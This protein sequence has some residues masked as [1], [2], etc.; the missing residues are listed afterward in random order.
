MRQVL[1]SGVTVERPEDPA[2]PA[3]LP[4]HV[5]E[6]IAVR[7][8]DRAGCP[9]SQVVL[10]EEELGWALYAPGVT[11][12]YTSF[13]DKLTGRV[14]GFANPAYLSEQYRR[15]LEYEDGALPRPGAGPPVETPGAVAEVTLE[16][17]TVRAASVRGDEPPALHPLVRARLARVP[18]R[19]R[20]RGAEWHPELVALGEA[21]R[22]LD[23]EPREV[24][25]HVRLWRVREP[26]DP[27]Q[28]EST[29]RPC[30]TCAQVLGLR[31]PGPAARAG[32]RRRDSWWQRQV[33]RRR[34]HR[35]PPVT[36]ARAAERIERVLAARGVAHEHTVFP[37]A[38]EAVERYL[39][40]G[41]EVQ[42]P[43]RSVRTAGFHIDPAWAADTA[44]T[45]ARVARRV[46][47]PLFPLG[48][49]GYEG[50]LALDPDRRV[51]LIDESGEWSLGT[52]LPTALDTLLLGRAAP[53]VRG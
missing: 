30:A 36:P 7:W 12:G 10:R 31:P 38:V 18:A 33:D 45:L 6:R 3:G 40:A 5:L 44:D 22:S 21:M 2:D 53:R 9:P 47:A 15:Q 50:F 17:V 16:S 41:S 27:R 14:A 19:A 37:A 1:P 24:E 43:G 25:A 28:G 23:A 34:L 49:A 4:P 13:V 20:V 32:S 8:A 26:A 48:L 11:A 46:G 35:R 52:G 42:V 51:F 29:G 39:D